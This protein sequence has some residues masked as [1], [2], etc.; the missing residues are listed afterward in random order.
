MV[1]LDVRNL[2]VDWQAR[3]D[4]W[5]QSCLCFNSIAD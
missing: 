2:G 4:F 1:V 5:F 3:E